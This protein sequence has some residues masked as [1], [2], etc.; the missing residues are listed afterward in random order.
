MPR[1]R[2]IKPE[3]WQNE[4]LA[5]C[6]PEA[7]LLAIGLLNYSD[8]EG[9]FKATERLLMCQIFPF[10]DDSLSAHG[11]LTELSN[12]GY[13][14]LFLGSDG[15]NYG[16]VVKFAEHQKVN[17][18]TP[19]KIKDLEEFTESSLSPHGALTVGKER[20]GSIPADESAARYVFSGE[21]IRLV[22]R[23][24][25]KLKSQY[26]N[27]DLDYQLKQL[28]LELRGKKNWFVEMNSKL[29]YR[30]KTPTHHATGT[31]EVSYL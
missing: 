12:I 10:N 19:S 6:S 23:D 15:K 27:I 11:M 7:R 13:I 18:P 28:D 29:N 14:R 9:Y 25:E 4:E 3:F 1:I 31:G 5:N 22:A 21:T 30:N 20:K 17:R 2:T 24:Y 16:Q 26:P 8:D